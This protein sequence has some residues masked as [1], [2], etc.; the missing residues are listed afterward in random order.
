MI[1]H[2][3]EVPNSD[4]DC[5][6]FLDEL[7]AFL[8]STAGNYYLKRLL[9]GSLSFSEIEAMTRTRTFKSSLARIDRESTRIF[10]LLLMRI[11]TRACRGRY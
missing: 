4:L 6:P 11:S 7:F 10:N 8:D 9:D 2:T 1:T 3:I 5:R